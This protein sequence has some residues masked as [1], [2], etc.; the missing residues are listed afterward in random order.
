[1][2]IVEIFPGRV[3]GGAEQYVLELGNA[4]TVRG[5]SVAYVAR[6]SRAVTGRLE[7][8]VPFTVAEI[9][10]KPTPQAIAQL[11]DADVVH[12]HDVHQLR[13]VM[14]WVEMSGNTAAK[15]VLTRHIARASRTWPWLRKHFMRIHKMMF[16]S[17]LA[18]EMWLDANPWMDSGKCVTVHNST[19]AAPLPGTDATSLRAQLGL[20]ENTLLMA[21]S[22][23]VRKSKGAEVIV[24]ALAMLQRLTPERNWAMVFIGATKPEGYEAKL[25]RIALRHGLDPSRLYFTGFS[26]NARSLIAQTDIGVLPSIVRE[27][28][29]LSVLEFMAA[30]LPVITTD[31][32]AQSE[33]VTSGQTGLLITPGHPEE[34]AGALKRL[35]ENPAERQRIG[36]AAQAHYTRHMSY[37]RFIDHII[38]N[39]S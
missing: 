25:R 20:P 16:V 39:F 2:K 15:V 30:G 7:G 29:G 21:Y 3:W 38:T 22:G 12:I 1:M 6:P 19:P 34:L 31:N 32:G 8:T 9:K 36:Q 23:R 11:A 26:N 18:K 10:G 4:L 14:K 5:H 27:S 37:N 28:F 17:D 13:P 33:F 35:I 24:K